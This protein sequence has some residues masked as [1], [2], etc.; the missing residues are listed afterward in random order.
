[1]RNT[2]NM[3]VMSQD[4]F[5]NFEPASMPLK[6][7]LKTWI[8]SVKMITD[9]IDLFDAKILNLGLEFDVSLKRTSNY[10][11]AIAEI[12]EELFQQITAVHP[13][14][15]EPFSVFEVE[16]ILND[17]DIINGVVSIKIKNKMG[18]GYSDIRHNIAANVSPDGKL[19][20]VPSNFV[21]EIKNAKDIVGKVK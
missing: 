1:M 2:L 14:I 11:S 19:I 10:A 12:R 20:Y 9:S 21:W 15:G 5:G 3:Y 7:N 8:N 18:A 16:R 13:Q 6:Q 17:L 4:R